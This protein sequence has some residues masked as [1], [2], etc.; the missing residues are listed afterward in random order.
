MCGE[1]FTPNK[2]E[3]TD[4]SISTAVMKS[5]AL[6]G[7]CKTMAETSDTAGNMFLVEGGTCTQSFSNGKFAAKIN[8]TGENTTQEWSLTYTSLQACA[9]DDTKKY[10]VVIEGVCTDAEGTGF[11]VGAVDSCGSTLV[12]KGKEACAV[13]VFPLEKYMKKLAPFTGAFIIIA[14]AVMCFAG[15]KFLPLTISFLVGFGV[16]GVC[17]LIG[18]NFLDPDNAKMWHLI[19]LVIAALA[20]GIVAGFCAF[21]FLDN[22]AVTILAFWVGILLALFALK[23]AQVQN[24]NITLGAAAVGGILGA[25]LGNKYQ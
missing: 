5:G 24:Q 18:Y 13:K 22:W 25:C 14:G 12:Y 23:L 7:D 1:S 11:E 19:V 4:G 16:T 9:G 2:T 21:K 17:S 3:F 10:T 15:S 8:D 20:F 6:E